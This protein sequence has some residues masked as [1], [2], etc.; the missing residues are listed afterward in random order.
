MTRFEIF[1]FPGDYE[2]RCGMTKENMFELVLET[3]DSPTPLHFAI[4][5]MGRHFNIMAHMRARDEFPYGIIIMDG[6]SKCGAG[7]FVEAEKKEMIS[8][9][10]KPP[11]QM[12][13]QSPDP[14]GTV[15]ILD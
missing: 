3:N 7:P 1:P 4:N 10:K 8:E 12:T 5:E 14:H 6:S 9:A 15:S 2:T 13:I 11:L